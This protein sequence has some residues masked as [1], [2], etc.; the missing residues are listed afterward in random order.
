MYISSYLSTKLLGYPGRYHTTSATDD[1]KPHVEVIAVKPQ[2]KVP[3]IPQAVK[4][5]DPEISGLVRVVALAFVGM[6]AWY[7]IQRS[8]FSRGN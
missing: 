5:E 2:S 8:D 3:G 4:V 6:S 7:I 1:P